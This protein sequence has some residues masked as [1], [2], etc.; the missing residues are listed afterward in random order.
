MCFVF[1]WRDIPLARLL[2]FGVRLCCAPLLCP[3]AFSA[4]VILCPCRTLSL[5]FGGCFWFFFARLFFGMLPACVCPSLALPLPL[6]GGLWFCAALLLL[7]SPFCV[8]YAYRWFVVVLFCWPVCISQAPPL[9]IGCRS[10]ILPGPCHFPVPVYLFHLLDYV[11]F[12]AFSR[13]G[14]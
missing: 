3:L 5:P 10:F 7:F 11:P 13:N 9:C 12:L 2:L 8:F 1:C 14:L 4:F 6:L